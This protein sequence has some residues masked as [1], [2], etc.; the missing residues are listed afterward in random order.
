MCING[1]FLQFCTD[2]LKNSANIVSRTRQ[3]AK[4]VAS[5]LI[6]PSNSFQCHW[7]LNHHQRFEQ[8]MS[9]GE[10]PFALQRW[11]A[12]PAKVYQGVWQVVEAHW[13]HQNLCTFQDL[14]S[15][16]GWCPQCPWCPRPWEAGSL[17]PRSNAV[18]SI[19]HVEACFTA[20]LGSSCVLF[21]DRFITH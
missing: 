18:K 4:Q 14:R 12:S 7:V 8:H 13:R 20:R 11:H 1:L 9:I 19:M 21:K 6:Y 15:E 17:L 10:A 2:P 3:Y 5:L 16:G